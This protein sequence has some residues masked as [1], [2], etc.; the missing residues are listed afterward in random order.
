MLWL[1]RIPNPSQEWETF[2]KVLD[3]LILH[4]GMGIMTVP[5]P[6][7]QRLNQVWNWLKICFNLLLC[8]V[9]LYLFWCFASLHCTYVNTWCSALHCWRNRI[10]PQLCL[11]YCLCPGVDVRSLVVG[12][13]PLRVNSNIREA[14]GTSA[15]CCAVIN[16]IQV[17]IQQQNSGNKEMFLN[18][19]VLMAR[20]IS[21]MCCILCSGTCVQPGSWAQMCL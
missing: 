11:C 10:L 5:T 2:L 17:L 6:H 7:T 20:R 9:F 1:L 18:S 21:E 14:V 4:F 8:D 19:Y 15:Q 12:F 3:H 13:W 16:L